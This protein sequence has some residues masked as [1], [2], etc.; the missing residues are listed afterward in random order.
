[1]TS[2]N[3]FLN[4]LFIISK[5]CRYEELDSQSSG[6]LL[7]YHGGANLS[8]EWV[9]EDS[10]RVDWSQVGWSADIGSPY[11]D[12]TKQVLVY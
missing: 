5:D 12:K 10:Y 9:A 7:V 8:A 2:I 3:I 6:K 1:M 11:T 4:A